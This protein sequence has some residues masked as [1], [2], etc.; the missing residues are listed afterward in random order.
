MMVVIL[1]LLLVALPLVVLLGLGIGM[2]GAGIVDAGSVHFSSYWAGDGWCVRVCLMRCDCLRPGERERLCVVR[3][4]GASMQ[5][6]EV[7]LGWC[8]REGWLLW[9]VVKRG[10][11]W[12]LLVLHV[13]DCLSNCYRS[14]WSVLLLCLCWFSCVEFD[15]ITFFGM[16]YDWVSYCYSCSSFFRYECRR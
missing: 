15:S 13:D 12:V 5:G 16:T 4:M 6:V 14:M 3:H 8:A 7:L 9:C 1:A 10:V 11:M 2:V